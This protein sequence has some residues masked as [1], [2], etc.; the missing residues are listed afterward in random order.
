[1]DEPEQVSESRHK[2]SIRWEGGIENEHDNYFSIQWT[3]LP[4]VYVIIRRSI[5]LYYE[6][7]SI[8]T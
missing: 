5:V 1:M 8:T 7:G 6:K 2:V 3:L 4:Q